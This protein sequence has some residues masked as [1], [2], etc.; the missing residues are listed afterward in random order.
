MGSAQSEAAGELV[1]RQS[2]TGKVEEKTTGRGSVALRFGFDC[3]DNSVR[4]WPTGI[5]SSRTRAR[6][7]SRLVAP[8]AS[9]TPQPKAS[10]AASAIARPGICFGGL[11]FSNKRATDMI[12]AISET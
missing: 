4:R 9:I 2:D 8:V 3:D 11:R 12:S 10:R 6:V 5:A 7:T 1:G